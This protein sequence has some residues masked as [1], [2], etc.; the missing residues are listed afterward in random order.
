M[1]SWLPHPV[2]EFRPKSSLA[3]LIFF[4]HHANLFSNDFITNGELILIS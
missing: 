4:T 3:L 2:L 1:E